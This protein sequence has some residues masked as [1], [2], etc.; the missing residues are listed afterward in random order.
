MT[1]PHIRFLTKAKAIHGDTYDYSKTCYL[2]S[3]SRVIITCKEHG[4]F[5]Q[6]PT[7]HLC[8]KGCRLCGINKLKLVL[9][10]NSNV[11]INKAKEVH[12]DKYDYS[13]VEYKDS[14]TKVI[15]NC[16]IHGDFTQAPNSHLAG[17]GCPKCSKGYQ[18]TTPEFI[19]KANKVHNYKYD[20]SKTVYK[21]SNTKIIINCKEHGDF[22]QTP[23]AHISLKNG[24]PKCANV[25]QYTTPEFI[26]KA[27]SIHNNKYSYDK[28]NYVNTKTKVTITC[29]VHGDFEQ[30]PN[31]H[32]AGNGCDSCD[33]EKRTHSVY[34]FLSLARQV[35]GDLYDYSNIDYTKRLDKVKII[36]S[37]HG[38]FWQTPANHL[39]G[40]GCPNCLKIDTEEFIKRA[41]EIHRDLYDYSKVVCLNSQTKVIITCKKHGDFEQLSRSHLQ[42]TGCPNCNLS[43]GELLVKK[44]LDNN[45]ISYIQQYIIPDEKY[46]YKY[47]FYLNK[48]N[49]LIEFHG[50]QHYEFCPYFHKTYK[51]FEHQRTR[52]KLKLWLA[53]LKKIP[54][55]ELNYKHVKYMS[56]D[57]FETFLLRKILRK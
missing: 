1:T 2:D 23:S 21:D 16:S 24:C 8:G 22:E 39:N 33:L 19:D 28:A 35:H 53:S 43:K 50:E 20:Y 9:T 18:Y 13:K 37:K 15:I 11:F 56:E 40:Q 47:D 29:P 51:D 46:L 55:I 26:D 10:S 54:L 41:K 45:N 3:H 38:E 36:C 42:G 32:L 48:E 52:D 14:K 12:Q 4:D 31:S 30:I 6:T 25:Y 27:N 34:N 49:I 7:K 5:E 57:E 44:I 17:N